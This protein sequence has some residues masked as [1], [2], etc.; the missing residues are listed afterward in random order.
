M[1]AMVLP[2]NYEI[3][4]DKSL[5]FSVRVLAWSLPADNIY[6]SLLISKD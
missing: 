3:Y 5:K 1:V 2:K 6:I 4:V